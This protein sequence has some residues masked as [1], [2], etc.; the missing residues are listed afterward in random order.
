MESEYEVRVYEVSYDC[1]YCKIGEMRPTGHEKLTSPPIVEHVCDH[2]GEIKEFL[3]R[4]YPHR[5][6]VRI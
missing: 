5:K 3:G 1:D 4:R 2:C 6:Y